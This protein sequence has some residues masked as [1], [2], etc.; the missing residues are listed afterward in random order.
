[1]TGPVQLH[2]GCTHA[3]VDIDAI[4]ADDRLAAALA[5]PVIPGTDKED[6]QLWLVRL[7]RRIYKGN[8]TVEGAC[9][10]LH[11]HPLPSGKRLCVVTQFIWTRSD[12]Q[13]PLTDTGNSRRLAT[14]SG[15]D[16]TFSTTTQWRIWAGSSW[17]ADPEGVVVQRRAKNVASVLEAEAKELHRLGR[18][19]GAIPGRP[20]DPPTEGDKLYIQGN[21]TLVWSQASQSAKLIGAMTK[22]VRDEPGVLTRN[23]AWDANGRL[24]ACPDATVEITPDGHVVREPRRADRLTKVMRGRPGTCAPRPAPAPLW[25]AYLEDRQPD[26]DVRAYIQRLVG[27][28]IVEGNPERLFAINI[29]ATSTGK[30]TFQEVIRHVLGEYA[31]PFNLSLFRGKTDEGPRQDIVKAMDRRMIF[32]EEAN[33]RWQLHADEVTRLTGNATVQARDLF[34]KKDAGHERAPAFMPMLACNQPP[35]IIDANPATW[36]R[37]IA[38]PW[39]VQVS[40]AEQD[41]NLREKICAQ[42][43]DGVLDWLLYGYDMYCALGLKDP[44][45]AIVAATMKL[46]DELTVRD[47]WWYSE[48]ESDEDGWTAT[49]ELWTAYRKWCTD[50]GVTDQDR[51]NKIAFGRWLANRPGIVAKIGTRTS[52]S[53]DQ[54]THTYRDHAQRVRGW[55]GA[56]LRSEEDDVPDNSGEADGPDET[57]GFADHGAV[58]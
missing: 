44:P 47:Q 7:Y 8:A 45:T 50:G 42:E 3:E 58:L 23:E 20:Q 37:L 40:E 32:T 56:H 5:A 46:R 49:E 19:L 15:T 17:Q 51:G 54:K 39:D 55:A 48:V 26:P 33:A 9:A 35:T 25:E 21:K 22:L 4:L 41:G 31:G 13:E 14:L 52:Q 29:G 12:D 57:G 10:L 43:T 2:L 6:L 53:F 11:R 16:T 30:T 34:A 38:L 36:R 28:G 18:A 24:L 27:Y 1:M